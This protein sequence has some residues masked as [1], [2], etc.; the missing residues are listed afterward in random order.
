MYV[1]NWNSVGMLIKLNMNSNLCSTI[2]GRDGFA[3]FFGKI[4]FHKFEHQMYPMCVR[5]TDNNNW[6]LAKSKILK[7]ESFDLCVKKM[8][9]LS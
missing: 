4:N 2:E 1:T 9:S 3:N 5:R 7:L 6:L 8:P